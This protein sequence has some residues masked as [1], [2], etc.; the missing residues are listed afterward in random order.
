MRIYD[1]TQP[2]TPGIWVWPGDRA[3][4]RAFTWRIADGESVNVGQFTMSCHTGTH[5]DATYHFSDDGETADLLPLE[6]CVGPCVVVPLEQLDVTHHAERVLV[7]AKGGAP[8]AQQILQHPALKLFG[9]DF[10][11]VD[12]M[13]STTLDAH[14]ALRKVGAVILE[15]LD[16]SAVPYGEYRLCALPLKLVGLD[17][18]PV[19]AILIES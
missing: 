18:A 2:V 14:H 4:E 10:V 13:D 16:L 17:A 1:I 8:T 19:R 7:K 6:K 12:P 11:S 5:M 9:T 3:Y 15:G